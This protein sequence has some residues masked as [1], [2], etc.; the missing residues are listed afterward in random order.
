MYYNERTLIGISVV[1]CKQYIHSVNSDKFSTIHEKASIVVYC[2]VESI[3]KSRVW[4]FAYSLDDV[5]ASM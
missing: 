2:K 5:V 1:V 3:V 4:H